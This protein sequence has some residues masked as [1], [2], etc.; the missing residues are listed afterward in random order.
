[1]N[2]TLWILIFCLAVT[3]AVLGAQGFSNQAEK[4]V[5]KTGFSPFFKDV[6]IATFLVALPELCIALLATSQNYSSMVPTYVSGANLINLLLIPAVLALGM[7]SVQL[8]KDSTSK[9]LPFLFSTV[10]LTLVLSFDGAI[11][12]WEGLV[13]L[14][15]FVAFVA[16]KRSEYKEG[17]WERIDH[18]FTFG[19]NTVSAAPLVLWLLVL[20]VGCYYTLTSVVALSALENFN[21]GYWACS[22]VALVVS[23]PELIFAYRATKNGRS[24]SAINVL[25]TSTILNSTIVLALPSFIKPLIVLDDVLTISSPYLLFALI[26]FALSVFKRQWSAY[27][28]AV[29]ALLYLVFLVQF[30][31]PLFS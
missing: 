7:G 17:L 26:L 2:T 11:N 5:K 29:L 14:A 22:L 16:S 28:G 18:W 19:N 4:L 21:P 6:I 20:G 27:E 30:L 24:D 13:L 15:A 31:N 12:F 10:L 25:I 1:M 8:S 9:Q 23:V 3:A